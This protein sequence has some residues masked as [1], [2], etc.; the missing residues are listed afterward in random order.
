MNLGDSL[1]AAFDF[2][3]QLVIIDEKFKR[4]EEQIKRLDEL[5]ASLNDRLHNL[6]TRVAVLEESRKTTD[7]DVRRV[8]TETVAAWQVERAQQ[9]L[10]EARVQWEA[11]RRLLSAAREPDAPTQ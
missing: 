7:A 4:H 9:E 11:E 3:K 6:S 1:K 2:S 5:T 10:R 8:I